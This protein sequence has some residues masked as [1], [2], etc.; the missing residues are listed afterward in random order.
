MNAAVLWLLIPLAMVPL[1][2]LFSM[3]QR[4]ITV[5]GCL[6]TGLLAAAAW[7]IP[8]G[9]VARLGPIT[10]KLEPSLLVLGRSLS[11]HDHDRPVLLLIYLF[12]FGWFAGAR[13]ARV[14]PL[15]IPLGLGMVVFLVAAVAVE[16]FLYAA[17]FIEMAVL[18]SIPILSPVG[19]P[20][21]PGI[22]RYLIFQ[23]L[24]MPFIL[25]TGWMLT[26][27]EAGSADLT[28]VIRASVMLGL[29][30]AFLL[31]VFPFYTWIPLLAEQ[32]HPYLAGFVLSLL[33]SITLLFGVSFLDNYAWLRTS[34]DLYVILRITGTMMVI[35]GGAW[36][37]FQR[38]LGRIM[39]YAVIVETG[40]SLLAIS[41]MG[42]GG[43]NLFAG[44]FLPRL[45][46]FAVWSLALAVIR[47]RV[48][49]LEFTDVKGCTRRMPLAVS[50]LLLAHLSV[51][52]MP[53]LASFPLKYSLINS[54]G[55][56]SASAA[57]LVLLGSLSLV[58]SAIQVLAVFMENPV[59]DSNPP[60]KWPASFLL[61]AGAAGLL[62]I[63]AV[64][65]VFLPWLAGLL[66]AFEHLLT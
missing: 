30:F 36:T 62:V 11:F 19:T 15:F 40:F 25:F 61:S 31:A 3:R 21:K 63:G 27:V 52:G 41:L 65:H 1:L 20:P 49:S 39:G 17:L 47:D 35:T 2:V 13:A 37:L 18:F 57:F 46:G 6:V 56:Q 50:C 16:P 29:G 4:V 7:Q 53:L 14:H 66:K 22:L 44:L 33:P 12:A 5:V 58:I 60:Q 28:S 59:R 24:G 8:I 23:T 48:G 32:A 54:L 43:L 51:A 38:H 55:A 64:P 10:L 34:P 45:L 42:V 9:E 26:G